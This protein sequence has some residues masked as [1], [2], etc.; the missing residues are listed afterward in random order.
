MTAPTAKTDTLQSLPTDA[1][2]DDVSAVLEADGAVILENFVDE[3]TLM[4]LWAD[5][6]PLFEAQG[7]GEEGFL[8]DRTRRLCSLMAKTLH[9]A[10]I[11]TE[12]RFFGAASHFLQR[13]VW[14]F[15]GEERQKF[16]PGMQISVGHGVQIWPGET[17]QGLHR[18]DVVHLNTHPGRQTRVLVNVALSDFTA[19]NGGT[20]IVPGSHLWDDERAPKPEESVPTVMAAGSA[21]VWLGSTYHCGGPNTSEGPRTGLIYA[22]DS[23]NYR[24]EENQYLAVPIEIVRRYPEQIQRLLGWDI[25]SPFCG[26][27]EMA[28]PRTFL[29]GE[30]THL[31]F[32]DLMHGR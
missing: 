7:W 18:D 31:G 27:V 21:V 20:R 17:L 9:S 22:L 8:G 3:A 10:A 4:N 11:V 2:V 32:A 28:D 30:R 16:T 23:A 25:A 13:P 15:V 26:Y 14:G 1:C 29:T 6:G 12:P 24:Q 19:E 5:L